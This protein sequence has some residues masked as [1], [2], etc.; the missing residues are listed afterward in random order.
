MN[1]SIRLPSR[2]T[3]EILTDTEPGRARLRADNWLESPLSGGPYDLFPASGHVRRDGPKL[4]V[5]IE[6]ALIRQPPDP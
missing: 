5:E 4:V 6:L 2:L 3:L 1:D